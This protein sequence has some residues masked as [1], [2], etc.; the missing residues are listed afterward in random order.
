SIDGAAATTEYSAPTVDGEYTVTVT[1]TD[2]AG[3]VKTASTTFTLDT[4]VAMPTITLDNDSGASATDTITNDEALT[5]SAVAADVTRVYSID[6]AAATTEY[7]APTVDG[8]YTVTVTDTDTAGNVKTASTTFTLDTTATGP[9]ITFE[10]AGTDSVY[11]SKELGADGTITA[12]IGLP[13]D[14]VTND[15]IS[16]NGEAVRA[17]TAEEIDAGKIILEV[18]P[19]A[20][21]SA[22]ITDQAGN[23]ST[24]GAA[25]AF[26]TDSAIVT[27]TVIIEAADAN[28][29]SV[30]N[31]AELGTDGTVSAIIGVTGSDVGDT[32]T[33]TVDGVKTVVT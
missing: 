28:G 31:A 30:Y 2:T 21:V 16:I 17:I 22:Q 10:S 23:I 13:S 8:E 25:T 12:T 4:T 26:T 15:L 14:A 18:V 3:N 24:K 1:D 20:E 9:I 19:G 11:N 33:Y 7:S 27:P 29:D 6:G 5:F 32:L